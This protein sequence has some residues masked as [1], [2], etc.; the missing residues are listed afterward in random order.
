MNHRNFLIDL[1]KGLD[2]AGFTSIRVT[3][4]ELGSLG[5]DDLGAEKLADEI[6][7][8]DDVLPLSF[9]KEN[10]GRGYL[11]LY[12]GND[13]WETVMDAGYFNGKV[14]CCVNEVLRPIEDKYLP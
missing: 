9:Q 1:I 7:D 12:C 8:L 6:L 5:F 2:Q 10:V 13:P 11:Q 14:E 3:D 4:S